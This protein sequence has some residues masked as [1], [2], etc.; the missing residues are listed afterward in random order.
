MEDVIGRIFG[1]KPTLEED[2]GSSE[3]SNTTEHVV[4]QPLASPDEIRKMNPQKCIVIG[5]DDPILC[6]RVD[7]YSDPTFSAWARPDPKYAKR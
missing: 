2:S 4:A 5:H 1:D 7:Y 6:R 3:S